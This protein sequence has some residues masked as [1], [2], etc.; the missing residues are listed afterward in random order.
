MTQRRADAI[1]CIEIQF[2]RRARRLKLR[3]SGDGVVRVT[4]PPGVSKRRA[5]S[6]ATENRAWIETQLSK[7]GELMSAHDTLPRGGTRFPTMTQ[8]HRYL[9]DRLKKLADAHGFSFKRVS[10]RDQKTRWGSCSANN[11]I[12][13]NMRLASLPRE[14][15][16]YVLLHELVH[17]RIRNH[18]PKFWET[19]HGL[20]PDGPETRKRL[21]DYRIEW[22]ESPVGAS[23]SEPKNSK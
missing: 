15:S 18:G 16:D 13:L 4:Q 6:F 19:L 12:S 23:L 7:L 5:M 11:C 14:L 3:V 9:Q 20:V 2:D 8:A 1:G 21:K 10:I 17:T 22:L